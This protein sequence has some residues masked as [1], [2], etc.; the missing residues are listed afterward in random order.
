MRAEVRYFHSPDCDLE[1]FVPEDPADVGVL[2]QILVGPADGPGEESFDVL[3]L[4]PRRSSRWVEQKGPLLG[5]H[6]LFVNEFD[7]PV[8]KKFLTSAVEREVAPSWPE[9]GER[10]GR[11]GKWEF[12]DYRE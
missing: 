5:R 6:H 7:W 3:V 9:L 12:E 4:T 11:I 2:V 1:Q 8:I 10:I